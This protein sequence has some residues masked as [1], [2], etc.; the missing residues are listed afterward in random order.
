M[1][2]NVQLA[3]GLALLLGVIDYLSEGHFMR[4]RGLFKERLVSFA[5]GLSVSYIFLHLFPQVYTVAHD[6][7]RLIFLSMLA[8]FVAYHALEKLIY[9]YAPR[10]EVI[11]DIELEHSLTLFFYHFVIGI[12]F[13]SLMQ[14]SRWDGVLF[15]I[16][17]SLHVII[18]ALPH[19]HRFQKMS[20]KAF[21]SSA[22]LLGV[23]VGWL[24]PIPTVIYALL[25][26][27]VAG[28]L[29]FVE[30]R[31]VAPRRRT[32]SIVWFLIGVVGYG[33][34]IGVSWL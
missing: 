27:L 3:V 26:G 10:D 18:N 8:G 31:E 34:L 25:F 11:N 1:I 7:P 16:P 32:E 4:K 5:A 20:V 30:A 23:M 19:A 28:I 21:F 24:V 13:L 33:F 15:F 14:Q 6:V 22:P 12:V 29:L 9:Q 17:V 2:S